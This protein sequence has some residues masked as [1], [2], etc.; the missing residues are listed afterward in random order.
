M[1]ADALTARVSGVL[2]PLFAPANTI[3]A[4][5]S[6]PPFNEIAMKLLFQKPYKS[7]RFLN[8][9]ELPNFVVLTGVNGAGKSHL[10]EALETGAINVEGI[11]PNQTHGAR[12]IRKFD[13]NSLV[14]QD[15]G[16]F[17]GG[18]MLQ[19]VGS[20]W[21]QINNSWKSVSDGFYTA[22]RNYL[23]VDV[24]KMSPRDLL[25][26]TPEKLASFGVAP[27]KID[28]TLAAIKQQIENYDQHITNQFNQSDPANRPRLVS[29]LKAARGIPLIALSQD[30]FYD[31]FPTNW[32]QIDLF[33]HSFSR[34]FSNYQRAWREN[35][36]RTRGQER[37]AKTAP[38]SEEQFIDKHG[39]PPWEFLNKLLEIANL[40]FRINQPAKWE[41]RP[42]EPILQDERR[43]LEVRFG[44]LSS[45]ERILMS[46][47]LCLYHVKD[48]RVN[49]DYPQ[50]LL[51]DEIDAPLHPS[52]TSSLLKTIQQALVVEKG[53]KVIL[54]T[55]SPS[56]VALS[57]EDSIFVMRKDQH[58]RIESVSRDAALG[59][60]T[61][62]V[63]TLSVNYEN[64]RQVFVESTHDVSFY[65]DLYQ[66]TK[67]K[68][69]PEI[70][71]SFI[72]SGGG[73]KDGNCD[74]VI[75]ISSML[76]KAGNST[77]MGLID[78]DL[79]NSSSPD[80][81]V[82]GE[83]ERYAI[84]NYILDPIAI[85]LLLLRENIVSPKT[86][87]F[88]DDAGYLS[89][90]QSE[91]TELIRIA[92]KIILDLANNLKDKEKED[93]QEV[94]FRYSE[95]FYAKFPRWLAILQGHRLEQA[96]KET[97]PPLNRYKN[98]PDLKREIIAK[99]LTDRPGLIPSAI[100]Q[101]L[102][103]IQ[104]SR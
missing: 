33:Q 61:E 27:D 104:N 56:T 12:L 68:L 84:D 93:I 85:G 81:K 49:L 1:N 83:N 71:I 75:S 25:A 7:I 65:S 91:S 39:E 22:I 46:F 70:S 55:H 57:P 28:A 48:A 102:K 37:G 64:R 10:L 24:E 88:S 11:P 31:E 89:I 90:A 51:F 44:D 26:L 18:Q 41:D 97:Y 87:G 79:K 67:S 21:D 17:S 47:A 62:G 32:Q 59:I 73:G 94:E 13:A 101:T 29:Q 72:A 80:V 53:I 6:S 50:V 98:E 23:P 19:E 52:M 30:E 76:R 58:R 77:V 99:V 34:L 15:T 3:V 2:L 38:L 40:D 5:V 60:L 4:L 92:Q 54:T 63:P 86:F 14:T 82:L 16:A 95:G 66:L 96:L 9:I 103:T 69:L 35:E 8:P 36:L 20:H 74:Q 43:G 78:W 42:F 45:G 100:I